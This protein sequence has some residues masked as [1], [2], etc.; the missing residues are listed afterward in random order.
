MV[1]NYNNFD[2]TLNQIFKI[3]IYSFLFINGITRIW[4]WSGTIQQH[5][6]CFLIFLTNFK[7]KYTIG[8]SHVK[9]D[10]TFS[11]IIY[12]W[13]WREHTYGS[14]L[15][16]DF[17]HISRPYSCKQKQFYSSQETAEQQTLARIKQAPCSPT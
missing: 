9:P 15:A 8:N 16:D 14:K 10:I 7:N 3:H 5:S 17:D 12:A 4:P 1:W 13:S 2:D 6:T 11:I